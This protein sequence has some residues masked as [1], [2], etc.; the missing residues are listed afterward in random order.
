[1]IYRTQ[2]KLCDGSPCGLTAGYDA[3]LDYYDYRL[4]PEQWGTDEVGS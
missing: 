2:S 3:H 4:S 1:M